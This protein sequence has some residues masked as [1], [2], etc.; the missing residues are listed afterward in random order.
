MDA[1]NYFHLF[2][3]LTKMLC[4]D[5]GPLLSTRDSSLN[6]LTNIDLVSGHYLT[7]HVLPY[8]IVHTYIL[9]SGGDNAGGKR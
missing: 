8:S 3:Q 4:H 7:L 6:A 9:Q 1:M 2:I 5:E